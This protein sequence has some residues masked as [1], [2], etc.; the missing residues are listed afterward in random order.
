VKSDAVERGLVGEV[1]TR[2]EHRGY[3]IVALKMVM[4]APERAANHFAEHEGKPFYGELIEDITKAPIVAMVIEGVNV[5]AGSRNTIG[6]TDPVKAEPGSIRGDFAQTIRRN[7]VHASDSPS[8]AAREIAIWFRPE[9]LFM[10]SARA[11]VAG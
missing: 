4:G 10:R 1:L 9:E 6:A 5:I 8:S 2:L 11:G 7:I 3:T